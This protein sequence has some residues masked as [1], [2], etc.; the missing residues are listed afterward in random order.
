MHFTSSGH[1][2]MGSMDGYGFDTLLGVTVVALLIILVIRLL[3]KK[4]LM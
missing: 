3:Q 4:P 1:E 2:F